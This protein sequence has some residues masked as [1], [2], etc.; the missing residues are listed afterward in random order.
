M[1][2]R[3]AAASLTL[4]V[5]M[6]PM[7]EDL[8]W[9]RTLLAGS[10]SAGGIAAMFAAPISGYLI[11]RYGPRAVLLGAAL[12]DPKAPVVIHPSFFLVALE[13]QRQAQVVMGFDI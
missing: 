4:G 1:F 12:I 5:F 2:V 10:A 3:N 13:Q 7:A 11:D 6:F 8:G 9:S